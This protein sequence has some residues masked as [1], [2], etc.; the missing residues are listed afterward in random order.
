MVS[1]KA[2]N[3][4][5]VVRFHCPATSVLLTKCYKCVIIKSV[6]QLTNYIMKLRSVLVRFLK[7]MLAGASASMAL[8]TL[9][10]PSVWSDFSV[11]LNSL[12]IAGVYGAVTGLLLGLN[13][14]ATWEEEDYL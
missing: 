5:A 14:Y 10:Q 6:Y 13:K 3:L 1:R 11:L 4:K 8:V 2:H 12:A 9:N 7:G